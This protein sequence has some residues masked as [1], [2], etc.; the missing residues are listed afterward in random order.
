MFVGNH[1]NRKILDNW[2]MV[3]GRIKTSTLTKQGFTKNEGNGLKFAIDQ[4]AIPLHILTGMLC[5]SRIKINFK[6]L[7]QIYSKLDI[8]EKLLTTSLKIAALQL[9]INS[10]ENPLARAID[11]YKNELET[12]FDSLDNEYNNSLVTAEELMNI[13]FPEEPL[14]KKVEL[15]KI[16]KRKQAEV[17]SLVDEK[18]KKTELKD[19]IEKKRIRMMDDLENSFN[20][21]H[22]TKDK[23]ND[24][25]Y[26][27][28]GEL[29]E[30][31]KKGLNELKDDRR[32]NLNKEKMG[33]IG[34]FLFYFIYYFF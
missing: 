18:R 4:P 28:F 1:T 29:V 7:E 2:N 25:K 5:S 34:F 15:E 30:Y 17:Q 26:A 13:V 9:T 11:E 10:F 14:K 24:E 12:L 23:F 20:E 21:V 8:S 27:V 6:E 19:Q 31:C 22:V 33:F 32:T 16:M 3:E